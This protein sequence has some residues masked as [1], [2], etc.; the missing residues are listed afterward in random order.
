VTTNSSGL[1]QTYLTATATGAITLTATEQSSGN[2]VQ[3]TVNAVLPPDTIALVSAPAQVQTSTVSSTAFSVRVMLGDGVTPAANAS[4]RFVATG[5]V[6]T[7]SACGSA[8]CTLTTNASG[9]A[10]TYFT[11]TAAGTVTLTA[12]EQSG[13]ASVQATVNAVLPPDT[14]ALVSAP[15]QVQTGV[16]STTAFAIRVMLGDGVTPAAGA[17]VH[18]VASGA[19][20]TFAAC[21]AASCTLTTNASG[22]A[23]SYMTATATGSITLTAT[24][25]SSGASVQATVNAV[26]PPDTIALVSAPAQVQTGTASAT[27]FAVRVML[28][29][30][31]TPAAGATVYLVATGAAATFSV[32]GAASCTLTTNASGIAQT[33]LTAT[34]PGTITLTA[35]EQSSGNSVQATVNA[36]LP[37]DTIALISAPAQVQTGTASAVA[38]S[39]RVL[40]GDGVTPT[41]NATVRFV[42]T[43]AAATFSACGAASCTLTTNGSGI[44]QSFFTATAAGTVTLTATEQ[45]GGASVQASVTAVLPPDIIA[46]VS[47]PAQ[48][49]T[50]AISS[51]PFAVRVLL[52]DAVTPAAG[53]TVHVVATGAAA[54][55][56]VCGAASCTLTTN[57]SGIAQTS[58]T[59]SAAGA[60]TLTATE[61]SS[62]ASVQ[63]AVTA[64]PPPVLLI[65]T[66]TAPRYLAAGAAAN[67]TF[68]V[69][70]MQ[71]GA[72]AAGQAVAWSAGNGISLGSASGVLDSTGSAAVTVSTTGLAG[73]A[74]A[75]VQGC[76]W[77]TICATASAFGVDPSQWTASV[78]SGAGQSLQAAQTLAPVVLLV[79]DPAG[80]PVQ[81]ATVNVYQTVAAREG[82]CP[83]TGR[84]PAAPVLATSQATVT[85]DAGGN[86]SITPLELPG[87]ASVVRIAA[88]TG[89]QGFV[90]LTLSKTP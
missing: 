32:C 49:Q 29:D 59:A 26:L 69:A 22:I 44:A 73:G 36:V 62:G 83:P 89:T 13:G 64:V 35:T 33:T 25:Q 21:G 65:S 66:L 72:P 47:A 56:A 15:T 31:V 50:G 6:A 84:C 74:Q 57:A 85:T 80:H 87:I 51:T 63:A 39:V 88:V 7:F 52:G 71:N 79:T 19:A 41:A 24:E 42:A 10:Q 8:L 20:S 48:V 76:A 23:R 37:P 67:W 12:T 9:V 54:T 60:I 28:G 30:G 75:T 16:A 38:L 34:A 3:V 77:T 78:T 43:G 53:A 58:I 90:S 82:I 70:A 46:L 2:S 14:I 40:L 27:A 11:A 17:T 5:A 1:A 18:F 61:Q 68:S 55:F 81:S 86:V 4:V 45:S